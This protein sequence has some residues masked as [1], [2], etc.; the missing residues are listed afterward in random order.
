M[1]LNRMALNLLDT[2]MEKPKKEIKASEQKESLDR[3]SV[4]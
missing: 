4:V 1:D 2:Y 3:K